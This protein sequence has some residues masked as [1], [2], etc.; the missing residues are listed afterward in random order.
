MPSYFNYKQSLDEFNENEHPR[1][2]EGKF[3]DKDGNNEPK[4]LAEAFNDI[5]Q[6]N[7]GLANRR[8]ESAVKKINLPQDEAVKCATEIEKYTVNIN[9]GDRDLINKAIYNSEPY[10]KITYSGVEKRFDRDFTIG[11]EVTGRL[12]SWSKEPDVAK[13]FSQETNKM[14]I[15]GQNP[16]LDISDMSY[17]NYEQ[18]VLTATTMVFRVIDVQEEDGI[19]KIFLEYKK[20]S[21]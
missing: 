18:E 4:T 3:T 15:V 14:L 10:N 11:D 19:Q 1:D 5:L 17:E 16:G 21:Q 2:K 20:R 8:I 7:I 13:K 12:I 6:G 9:D